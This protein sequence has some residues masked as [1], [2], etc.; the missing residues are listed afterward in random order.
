MGL[1]LSLLCE[2][3]TVQVQTSDSSE[4]EVSI[5]ELQLCSIPQS[6]TI[7]HQGMDSLLIMVQ[8]V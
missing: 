7:Y 3:W 5:E 2:S 4:S 6:W 8:Y 1:F